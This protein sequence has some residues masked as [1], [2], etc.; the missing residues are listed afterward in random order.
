MILHVC[1]SAGIVIL[2]SFMQINMYMFWMLA[3]S[4]FEIEGKD[5]DYSESVRMNHFFP[6][7]F[8]MKLVKLVV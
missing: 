1:D 7:A 2:D 4:L 5:I 6:S 3:L 8:L